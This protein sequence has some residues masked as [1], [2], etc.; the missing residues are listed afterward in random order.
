MPSGCGSIIPAEDGREPVGNCTLLS[1][2]KGGGFALKASGSNL[3]VAAG[4]APALAALSTQ[5]LCWLGY[6]TFKKMA[7][8]A[9]LAPAR[10]RLKDESLGS[11]H[12]RA[13]KNG[14]TRR[15]CSPSRE[16]GTISLAK[17][18]GSF[19]RFTFHVGARGRTCTCTGPLLRRMSLHWTTRAKTSCSRSDLHRHWTGFKPAASAVGLREQKGKSPWQDLHPH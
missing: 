12:S 5:C 18:P 2:L 11:L 17:N 16:C 10:T 4:V 14:G 9:G 3:V 19:V 1:R 15:A 7:R 8:V 6:A 13:M